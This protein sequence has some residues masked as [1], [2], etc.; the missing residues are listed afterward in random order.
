M[1][2]F[3]IFLLPVPTLRIQVYCPTSFDEISLVRLIKVNFNSPRQATLYHLH[4]TL[5]G[6]YME[7]T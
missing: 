3:C 7:R 1:S 2:M 5:N 6:R 4:I